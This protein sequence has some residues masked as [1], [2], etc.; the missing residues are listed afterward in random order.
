LI[1][2]LGYKGEANGNIAPRNARQPGYSLNE[3]IL[4]G[5][6]LLDQFGKVVE[7]LCKSCL[8]LELSCG[9]CEFG[10]DDSVGASEDLDLMF[11]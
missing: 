4:A 3:I 8:K 10:W 1:S 11:E 2:D 7:F 5:K 9:H 6:T